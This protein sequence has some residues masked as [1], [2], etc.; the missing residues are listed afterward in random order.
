LRYLKVLPAARDTDSVPTSE[1]PRP[2]RCNKSGKNKEAEA[3]KP[4]PASLFMDG[5]LA[6]RT[7]LGGA[8]E[9]TLKNRPHLS[10]YHNIKGDLSQLTVRKDVFERDHIRTGVAA[11]GGVRGGSAEDPAPI[12]G[13]EGR[14]YAAPLNR[15]ASITRRRGDPNDN[16]ACRTAVRLCRYRAGE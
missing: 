1:P 6:V 7:L 15:H 14:K 16:V 13:K 10:A 3:S 5:C 8:S 9:A 11:A 2:R 12:A 4:A